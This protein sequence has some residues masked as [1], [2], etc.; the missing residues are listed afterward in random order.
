MMNDS[1]ANMRLLGA[2]GPVGMEVS[3]KTLI[4]RGI[5]AKPIFKFVEWEK[6]TR[7][8]YNSNYQKA[9]HEGITHCEGRNRVI[10]EYAKKA[11][12]R[13]LPT[14]VLIQRQE[15]GRILKALMKD[16]GLKVDYIF[17]ENDSNERKN[18]LNK[19]ATGKSD[20]L[21]GSKIVDVGVDVPAIGL[22]IQAGGGKAEVAYRQRIGRGLRE[23]RNGPNVCFILDFYDSHNR[24]LHDHYVERLRVL[25]ETPGFAENILG[26]SE[27]FPWEFFDG[28]MA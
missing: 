22:V 6:P 26:K 20:A 17:G 8:R 25:K 16:A 7:L 1:E 27:D 23:K 10:V 21:I 13:K 2:F 3:E 15:H 11:A 5:N 4:D 12:E 14:L 28:K 18:A 24:Y 9:I 19:L